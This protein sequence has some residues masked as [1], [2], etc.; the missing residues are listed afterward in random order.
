MQ[1]RVLLC[2]LRCRLA[3]TTAGFASRVI[4]GSKPRRTHDY[5]L[6]SRDSGSRT[7]DCLR[8]RVTLRQSVLFFFNIGG[9]WRSY[10]VHSAL[11]PLLA[12][13]TCPGWLW[14]WRSWWTERFWQGKR[15]YSEKTCPDATLSTT[16]PTCQTRA[17]TRAA[18]VGSQHELVLASIL[19]RL[20]TIFFFFAN[21]SL[22]S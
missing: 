6:R 13:Y 10:W 22:W 20:T 4:L 1:I 16:N 8:F 19:L 9:G 17:R 3:T 7:T 5:I 15:K 14:G 21:E 11:R 18:A 12:Y 2:S